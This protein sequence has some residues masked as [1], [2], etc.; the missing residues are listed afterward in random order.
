MIEEATLA[1]GCFWCI[2]SAF[3][4]VEG[5][6]STRVGYTG[7]HVVEPSYEQVCTGT[8]GHYEA[9]EIS[10][11]SEK[12]TYLQILDLFWRSIDPL[13]SGGQFADR[14]PQYKTAIFYADARQKRLAEE[15]KNQIQTLFSKPIVTQILPLTSF[16]EAE[17]YHQ[18]YC[19]KR[20]ADYKAYANTH[21]PHLEELWHDKKTESTS[22]QLQEHLTPLQ[23]RVT[24]NAETEPPFDNAYW[25]LHEEGIYVDIITGAPL[26]ISSDKFDSNCGWPSF[27]RPIDSS[28][29]EELEDH[30]FGMH[31]TEVRSK[32]SKSHLGHV[33]PDGPAPE[34][35]RYCIN[36]A[37]LRFIPKDRM[38]AEGYG[39]YIPLLS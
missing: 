17:E 33:F 18:A 36:S 26:F 6:L 25:D 31:R 16:F 38:T 10:F 20:P 7:G 27:T 2:E 21:L 13:D 12:I 23:Y 24:Q 8:T 35:L 22:K 3:M 30:S 19:H 39:D 15:S 4:D 37:S 5:V 29:I 32:N 28:L 9:I 11:D 34:G 1:G 14:G